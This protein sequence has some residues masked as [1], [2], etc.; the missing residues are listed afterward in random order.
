MRCKSDDEGYYQEPVYELI[1]YSKTEFIKAYPDY[2]SFD[3]YGH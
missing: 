3:W 2:N 1:E